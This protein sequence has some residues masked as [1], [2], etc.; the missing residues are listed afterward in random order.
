MIC[1]VQDDIFE[2]HF[3]FHGPPDTD[4][5][6]GVYTGRINLPGRVRSC[7]RLFRV[8]VTGEY[9]FKPP[10]IRMITVRTLNDSASRGY[11]SG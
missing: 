9:P 10:E 5:A 2:W 6:G 8:C 3:M 11:G 7:P 1:G 4:F